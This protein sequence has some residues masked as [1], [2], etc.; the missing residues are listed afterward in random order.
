MARPVPLNGRT[1]RGRPDESIGMAGLFRRPDGVGVFRQGRR[2][3]G[4]GFPPAYIPAFP[5][6][7]ICLLLIGITDT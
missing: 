2:D 7:P 4:N 5:Y 3:A 1:R 6:S